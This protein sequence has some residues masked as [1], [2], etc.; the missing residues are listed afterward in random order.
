MMSKLNKF[1]LF[2][3][4]LVSF[5]FSMDIQ[6]N[7]D[8]KKYDSKL[9]IVNGK[10]YLNVEDIAS[11]YDAEISYGMVS[12]TVL[13]TLKKGE[14]EFK[15]NSNTVLVNSKKILFKKEAKIM[16]GTF[17]VPLGFV[18]SRYFM[19]AS[20]YKTIW[21]YDEKFLKLVSP[22]RKKKIDR[23]EESPPRKSKPLQKKLEY[24]P[25]SQISKESKA[26]KVSPLNTQESR[27]TKLDIIVIDAGHGG[28]DPGAIARS[29]ALEKDLNLA[30]AKKL[31]NILEKK[32]KKKVIL[33]R[34]TDVFIPLRGRTKIGNANNADLFVSIHANAN[35]NKS[36]KGF[37]IYFLSER[38]SDDEA[39]EVAQFENAV[40][41]YEE[42]LEAD[43]N[44][45]L[46]SMTLNEYINESSEVSFFINDAV[47]TNIVKHNNRGVK[48]AGFTVLK[49][50]KMPAVLVEVGYITN[51]HD[52]AFMSSNTFKN[53]MAEAIAEGIV[54]YEKNLNTR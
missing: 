39:A 42:E 38:A 51:I 26:L 12:K 6:V 17:Y 43:V 21:S 31:A 10:G 27:V 8:G 5:L 22:S 25:Q 48:Q 1:F 46:W 23:Q 11:F 30:L 41:S 24:L 3:F 18:L 53:K 9:E 4:L 29:G 49:G 20:G 32:Y 7:V 13:F 15:A 44:T 2:F 16:N 34:D 28:K 47:E 36:R 35:K 54:D 50:A 52:L 14:V 40:I 19:N 45:I 37:E 33:T